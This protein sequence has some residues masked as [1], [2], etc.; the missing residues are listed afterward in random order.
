MASVP[1]SK[2]TS[3]PLSRSMD[4]R[5]AS[6]TGSFSGSTARYAL[7]Q[8]VSAPIL[9]M[10]AKSQYSALSFRNAAALSRLSSME[11]PDNPALVSA[12]QTGSAPASVVYTAISYHFIPPL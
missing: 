5:A 6:S 1:R 8:G 10:S 3:S 7:T 2:P 11:K 4:A 12:P 9:S